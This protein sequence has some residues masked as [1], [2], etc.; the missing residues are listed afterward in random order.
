MTQEIPAPVTK[1]VGKS[2]VPQVASSM[3]QDKHGNIGFVKDS[4]PRS[5][6]ISTSIPAA[7]IPISAPTEV[8]STQ[9][10]HSYKNVVSATNIPSKRVELHSKELE[11]TE[12]FST[13]VLEAQDELDDQNLVL[14]NSFDILN[15]DKER[16]PGVALIE[17]MD[18]LEVSD[19]LDATTD[20]T[21]NA[22]DEFV[23]SVPIF[24]GQTDEN[25]EMNVGRQS[26]PAIPLSPS[27]Q[28]DTAGRLS[29]PESS[30]CPQARLWTLFCSKP[31]PTLMS[32]PL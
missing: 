22:Y 10:I 1:K 2:H 16:D 21:K 5:A 11:V 14:H 29:F 19:S 9:E 26:F 25:L 24:D 7:P 32:S 20:N 17:D 8:P 18:V 13:S 27:L 23:S 12:I 3:T 30:L 31:G 15:H 4:L 28:D 6:Q